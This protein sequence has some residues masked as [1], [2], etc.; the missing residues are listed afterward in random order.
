MPARPSKLVCFDLGGV[1]IRICSG[2]PEV[3][4]RMNVT[5]DVDIEQAIRDEADDPLVHEYETGRIDTDKFCRRLAGTFSVEPD[6]VLQALDTWLLGPCGDIGRVLDRLHAADVATACLS[7]TNARH[8]SHM[9][10]EGHARLPLDRLTWRFASRQV[11]MMKPDP[12]LYRHVEAET[13]IEPEAILFFD[14]REENLAPAAE[15][16]WRTHLIDPAGDTI[17]QMIEHLE[18]TG[19]IAIS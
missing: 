16:G 10:G 15:R 19:V 1:L 11:G 17:A 4:Q 5:V 8:W 14:D 2:W 3:L 7:N 18:T 6:V 12:R 9:T 13:R